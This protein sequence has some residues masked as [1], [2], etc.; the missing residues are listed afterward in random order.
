MVVLP[1]FGLWRAVLDTTAVV[2]ELGDDGDDDD[3]MELGTGLEG[4][5]S[6]GVAIEVE[7]PVTVLDGCTLAA[8][9]AGTGVLVGGIVESLW[10]G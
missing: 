2:V 7:P 8:T 3:G 9:V 6:P 1:E 4:G 10:S 5:N